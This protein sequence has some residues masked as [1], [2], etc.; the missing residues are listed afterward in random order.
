VQELED[1]LHDVQHVLLDD[2]AAYDA[3]STHA[4]A[5][6]QQAGLACPA[7]AALSLAKHMQAA[8]AAQRLQ[9]PTVRHQEPVHGHTSCNSSAADA[10][11]A[12]GQAS[13][14][15]LLAFRSCHTCSASIVTNTST[16]HVMHTY[17][18]P[19]ILFAP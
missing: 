2:A 16:T 19:H 7:D 13:H 4:D 14:V 17:Y 18:M 15:L 8:Y 11:T 5:K 9:L 12:G 6:L 3:G 1:L 10:S